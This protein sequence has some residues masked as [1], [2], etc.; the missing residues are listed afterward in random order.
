MSVDMPT[1]TPATK[2]VHPEVIVL[3]SDSEDEATSASQAYPMATS[4]QVSSTQEIESS[5]SEASASEDGSLKSRRSDNSESSEGEEGEENDDWSDGNSENEQSIDKNAEEAEDER[6]RANGEQQKAGHTVDELSDSKWA[7]DEKVDENSVD[8]CDDYQAEVEAMEEQ[9]EIKMGQVP[10]PQSMDTR[11]AGSDTGAEPTTLHYQEELT[12]KEPSTDSEQENLDYHSCIMSPAQDPHSDSKTTLQELEI[13]IDPELQNIGLNNEQANNEAE[14]EPHS[15]IDQGLFLDGTAS[16]QVLH[17]SYGTVLERPPELQH[18]V[19]MDTQLAEIGQSSMSF[20]AAGVLPTPEHVQGRTTG[21]LQ[22]Q[23]PLAIRF[24]TSAPAEQHNI[25]AED[26]EHEAHLIPTP[27]EG[28]HELEEF[29][30]DRDVGTPTS[31]RGDQARGVD[32]YSEDESIGD[33]DEVQLIG[34]ERHYPGLRSKLSYFAPLATLVDHYNALVDT[35][36]AVS[37]VQPLCRA[38]SGKKDYILTLQLTD[39]SMA[40]ATL[41]AQ[42]IRPSKATLPLVDEGNAVLLRNFRV[43]SFNRSIMLTSTDTSAWAVFKGLD[44]KA[45]TD[46]HPVEYGSEEQIYATDVRQWY[47]ETGMAMVADNQLQASINMESR[48]GTP[49]SSAALSDSGSID[50]TLRDVRGESSFP[51]R[52]SRR[53][54]KSHRRITIHEL[55][56]GRRYTEVG[57]PSGKESIHE[58]RDGTVYAN[59]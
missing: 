34:V 49:A 22:G 58:L 1:Q 12:V 39:Q 11:D 8:I 31:F 26:V 23:M 50:S 47:Q 33:L 21:Q 19:L 20:T 18:L 53:G 6:E 9:P 14:E 32:L 54:K 44:D 28:R 25:V 7:R 24:E 36:S 45:L 27:Q 10:V 3:D 38:A 59:L 41:Y 13:V 37:E 52:G 4:R 56:D 42:I 57:S 48:E 43:K 40:G 5:G 46:G 15:D 16:L 30:M 2:K 17:D 55:R 35:I 29:S 51:S